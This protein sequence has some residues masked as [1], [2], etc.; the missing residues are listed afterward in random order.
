MERGA[1]VAPTDLAAL[2]NRLVTQVTSV[3]EG[4]IVFIN[5]SARDLELLENLN[6]DV[7]KVGAFPMITLGCDRIFKKYYAEVPEKYDLQPPDLELKLA[8]MPTTTI[9]VDS[10]EADDVAAGV[11][12]A[13]LAAETR[14][15]G[16]AETRRQGNAGKIATD[17]RG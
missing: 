14:R 6:T 2:S 13:R 16:D 4:E 10:N 1:K 12:P 7:R 15:Q 3:K 11:P 8:T 9:I 17:F 5:G